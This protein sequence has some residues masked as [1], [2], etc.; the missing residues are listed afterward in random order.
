MEKL[1]VPVIRVLELK[2]RI[3]GAFKVWVF[4]GRVGVVG[5]GTTAYG[6]K[7]VLIDVGNKWFS[8]DG[9]EG[10]GRSSRWGNERGSGCRCRSGRY[11]RG[12]RHHDIRCFG[13]QSRDGFTYGR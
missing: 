1:G 7:A 2:N 5:V 3:T 4:D 13:L 8:D 12:I 11:V 9:H 10:R 6:T